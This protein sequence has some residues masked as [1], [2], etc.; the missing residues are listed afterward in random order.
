M[1]RHVD[2]LTDR[3]CRTAGVGLHHDGRGLYL[4]CRQGVDGVTKSWLLRYTLNGKATWMG[5]GPYPD[6]GLA[7]AR[8]KA[9]DARALKAD[10]GDPLEHKRAVRAALRQQKPIKSA[11]FADAA[12]EYLAAREAGWRSRK[13]AYQWRHTLE[14]YVLPV[15]GGMPVSDV[16]TEDVLRVLTPI[17]NTKPVTA[18]RV[19]ERV[20]NVLDAAKVRGHRSAENCARWKGHLDHWLPQPSKVRAVTH[21]AAMPYRDVAG[22]MQA[23]RGHDTIRAL[24][25]EFIIL[26]A[27]RA[28]EVLGMVWAEFDL[29]QR[30]WTIPGSRMKSGRP[31]RVPLSDQAIDLI[32]R[33]PHTNDR[34]FPSSLAALDNLRWKMELSATTH[35]FRS[36]F[37][38][39]AAECTSYPREIIEQC[40]AHRTG[41][42]T[43]LAYQRSDLLQQRREL[44]QRWA[45][46]C[47]ATATVIQLRSA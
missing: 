24:A 20:E 26:T 43:E 15:I 5:L 35:G 40:L 41:D 36:T 11:T 4:T 33:M 10:G 21:H 19:R 47:T 38:T 42:A 13:H 29:E 37:R 1:S 28:G 16:T 17:W 9:Q 44:M 34:V 22:F 7:R 6:I 3:T 30:L 31:H 32:K 8:Q 14:D 25:L 45:D 46:Y 2:R 27:A 23:L 12:R 39:W 18:A